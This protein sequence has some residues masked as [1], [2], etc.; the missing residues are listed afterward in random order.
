MAGV[1][2]VQEEQQGTEPQLCHINEKP[3]FKVSEFFM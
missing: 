1:P 2:V 3:K